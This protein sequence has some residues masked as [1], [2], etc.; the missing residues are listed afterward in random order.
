MVQSEIFK[1]DSRHCKG[2][3][4]EETELDAGDH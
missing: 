1:D 3:E 4:L 2:D